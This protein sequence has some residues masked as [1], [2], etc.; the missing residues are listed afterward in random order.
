MEVF[1]VDMGGLCTDCT[2]DSINQ[3]AQN[4]LRVEISMYA[5]FVR[6]R[7]GSLRGLEWEH[8]SSQQLAMNCFCFFFFQQTCPRLGC[9][10]LSHNFVCVLNNNFILW[11][12]TSVSFPCH[13]QLT[14]VSEIVSISKIQLKIWHNNYYKSNFVCKAL[15]F[16]EVIFIVPYDIIANEF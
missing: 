16:V 3:I 9:F 5:K 8:L 13:L 11:D 7:Y 12:L 6:R 4:L 1:S 15:V 14:V 2:F 10:W